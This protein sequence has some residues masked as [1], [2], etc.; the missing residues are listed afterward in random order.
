LGAAEVLSEG[1]DVALLSYGLLV[2]EA[3]RAAELLSER[4]VRARVLNLRSLVPLDEEAVLR[5]ARETGLLVTVE[6]HFLIGGLHSIL[7]ELMLRHRLAPRVL[8]LA[9]ERRWFRPALLPDV[10]EA[11]GFAPAKIADQI[12]AALRATS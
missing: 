10:L 1:H 9:L 3:V 2:G 5:A 12:V 7:A 4:G 8:P 6:D 11:E